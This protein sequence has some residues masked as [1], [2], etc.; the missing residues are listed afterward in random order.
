MKKILLFIC[1]LF[2]VCLIAQQVSQSEAETVARNFY[3]ENYQLTKKKPL[4]IFKFKKEQ[5]TLKN[6]QSKALYVFNNETNEGFVIVSANKAVYPILAYSLNESF[7]EKEIPPVVKE[8]LDGYKEQIETLGKFKSLANS[9]VKVAWEKYSDPSFESK[10]S[11][12]VLKSLKKDVSPLLTTTWNQGRY[13][14][15]LCPET[16]SG[17]S[18]GHVWAG[19]VATAQGQIMKYY[20]YPE[21]G[22]GEH[23]YAHSVYGE[24]SANFGAATYNWVNM[25]NSLGSHNTD[26]ATLLYHC[27]VS[28]NM[29]YGPS[30]SG[31]SGGAPKNSLIN[32]FKYSTNTLYTSKGNYTG[33]DWK[34]LLKREIDEGRPMYYVGR[35][36][37]G[38]AFNCDG[39]QGDDY[40]H[41]NWG[42]GGSYNGY[43]YLDD[44][45]PGGHTFTNS[46]AVLVGSV[47]Q[48]METDL[49]ST[50]AI[51]L[52]CGV[53]YNGTTTDGENLVNTYMSAYWHSTGKEKVHKITTSFPGRISATITNLNGKNLDVYILK[54]ANRN[55]MLAYGDSVAL[56]DNT[57]AGTYYVLVDGRYGAEGSYTLEVSCPDI[58][59]DLIVENVKINPMS[60]VAG[61]KFKVDAR[62]RN[63]GNSVAS[64]NILNFY[65][66]NDQVLSGEDV[67][68]GNTAID[69]LNSQS[70][71]MLSKILTLPSDT[72]SGMKY[73]ILKVDAND[74]VTETDEVLNMASVGFQIP[75]DGIM[76]CSSAVI[77]ENGVWYN[78]NSITNGEANISNY[79]WFFGLDN[80]E[81][82]HEFTPTYSGLAKLEFTEDLEGNLN[83]ILLSGCNENACI[84][85]FALFHG[86]GDTLNQ[87]FYVAGGITYYLVADGDNLNGNSEGPYSLKVDFPEEC[88]TPA[89]T[90]SSPDRCIGDG[91]VFLYTNWEYSS[92]QWYKDGNPMSGETNNSI[93][94]GE[95]GLYT[96]KVTE[97]ECT[98]ESEEI[99]V[100][101]SSKPTASSI[102]ALSGTEFCEG[103]SVTLALSTGAGYS[104]QWTRN[105]NDI[106]GATALTFDAF[107]SGSYKAKVTN[108][109]CT[110][111]TN[112]IDVVVNHSAY[113][114]GNPLLISKDSLITCWLFDS[115]GTDESG[116]G[117]YG[118]ISGGIQCKDRDNK[119]S[120]FNFNGIDSYIYSSKQ[121]ENPD[122]V[123]VA[124]WFKTS[125]SGPIIGFDDERFNGASINFGRCIYL[126]NNGML[127]FGVDDG[128]KN[129]LISAKSYNDDKWHLATAS[130]SPEGMK[131]YIDGKLEAHSASIT[132]GKVLTG[133]WKVSTGNLTDWPDCSEQYL[134]G[135]VDDIRIYRRALTDDEIEVLYE[136]QLISI[137]AEDEVIC[138]VSGSTNL[139]IQNSESDVS[140][141]LVYDLS[142][143]PIGSA[144]DGSCGTIY[145]PTGTLIATTNFRIIAENSKTSCVNELDSIY[146]IAV[147]NVLPEL[148]ISSSAAFED[149]CKGDTVWFNQNTLYGGSTPIYSWM[150]NGQTIGNSG[151]SFNTSELENQDV[152]SLQMTSSVDCAVP[153]TVTSNEIAVSINPLPEIDLG[154]D[155]SIHENETLVLDAG[156]GQ[157]GYLWNTEETSQ[158]ITVNGN[159][160]IGEYDYSVLVTDDYNCSNS[161]TI[162]IEIK[163]VLSSHFEKERLAFKAWPNPV[164]DI[165]FLELENSSNNE[166]E[167]ELVSYA[168]QKGLSKSYNSG[169]ELIADKIYL[170]DQ[171]QGVYFIVL[172]SKN[173]GRKVVKIIIE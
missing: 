77:L 123:T 169:N 75:A 120:A 168:G 171:K 62:V 60:I 125:A 10:L 101:Y 81:V 146:T 63:I 165:L 110:I 121:F 66:S 82:I 24:Q 100:A 173:L 76:D 109:S 139:V 138:A 37:G 132:N 103:S 90:G 28:V 95:N 143:T 133:Y 122:T 1:F 42:W 134:E 114:N 129:T 94:V 98:V 84:N 49:D 35:G 83:L 124:I 128:T 108:E 25:P 57:Q 9:K 58:Q 91:S 72:E 48:T 44:L 19:C 115:W 166:I 21:H 156:E 135:A 41:F 22:V 97:N 64:A 4:S 119:V 54:Y 30:G 141:Q 140:Y 8:W 53:P 70:E 43:F 68:I 170:G 93:S 92:F 127:R 56:A 50:S 71:F 154:A 3:L 150:I 78:G 13:Y 26:V 85:S 74:M 159:I 11:S 46:Q 67:Y 55:C 99:Q 161:D 136:Q 163:V 144:V 160:G 33:E 112:E 39:Y 32:Y 87:E 106:D 117:N 14:N 29:N 167:L 61:A 153:K 15:A 2:P 118:G 164:K 151:L 52:S 16:V 69:E 38:H 104:Y 40:F 27:G 96:V 152:V 31:A 65:V 162:K 142:G 73:L 113:E 79:S 36:S 12:S 130:L 5:T 107:E 157:S 23:S 172:K 158:Q 111:Q 17:G 34:N 102:S 59:A 80:K 6:G 147:G 88:P 47:P 45:T 131:L 18:G 20:G 149:F 155:T 145:L 126:D 148:S 105:N 7:N 86:V 89:L 137:I 51:V 116:Y